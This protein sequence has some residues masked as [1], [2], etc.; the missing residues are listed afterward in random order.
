MHLGLIGFGAIGQSVAELTATLDT[1][2]T[3]LTVLVR[4]NAVARVEAAGLTAATELETLLANRPDL[5]IECAGHGAVEAYVPACLSAGIDTVIASVGALTDTALFDRISEAAQSS[6][7]RAILAP[8]AVGGID[9]LSALRASG[10]DSVT[11]TGRK[12]P[13]AWAGSPAEEL[14]DLEALTKATPFFEGTAREAAGR[15]P[16]NANVAATVAF[17]GLGLDATRATLIADPDAPGN[18]HEVQVEARDAAFT[19]RIEGRASANA[20]TSATT[21]LSLLREVRNRQGP[22]AI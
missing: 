13:Q 20:R 7:A 16:K 10:I 12:P 4:P 14:L 5:I 22:I 21:A 2:L 19:I 9:L 6:G 15:F 11:Y 18:I 8:G 1:P 3:G 17:A